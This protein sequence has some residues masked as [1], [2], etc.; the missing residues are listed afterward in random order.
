[1]GCTLI[2]RR[3]EF[4]IS[5]TLHA[6]T[7]EAEDKLA[8]ANQ[9]PE[10]ALKMECMKRISSVSVM[11]YAEDWNWGR[12][13]SNSVGVGST[14]GMSDDGSRLMLDRLDERAARQSPER[15]RV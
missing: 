2:L 14:I 3:T 1:M 7:F 6:E 9:R 10:S 8:Q 11:K 12:S 4:I 5:P 15:L 13:Q